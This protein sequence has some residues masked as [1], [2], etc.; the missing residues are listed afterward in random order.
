[1]S[2]HAAN[3]GN[4][5]PTAAGRDTFLIPVSLNCETQNRVHEEGSQNA[6]SEAIWEVLFRGHSFAAAPAF[7]QRSDV[8]A[9]ETSTG[10]ALSEA[11]AIQ[12]AQR[13]D[14]R[15]FERLYELHSRRVYALCLRMVNNKTDAE[16]MTQDAFLQ[17]FR[18]ID[19]FRGESGFSTWLHRIT[20]NVV[21]MRLRRKSLVDGSLEEMNERDEES[22]G[23]RR[24]F[25]SRD[26]HLAGLVDRLTLQ[27]AIEHLPAGYRAIFVLHD[28]EGYE[29][30]EIAEIYGCSI[31]NSKS[32]LHK[33]RLRIRELLQDVVR[34]NVCP[35]RTDPGK[36]AKMAIA[37]RALECPCV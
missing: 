16:D 12:M 5:L 27:R 4:L 29:H 7:V 35:K 2:T 9:A 34:E 6:V 18:K 36:A 31:G 28:V 30:H 13:G 24:E 32:Q 15:A 33:A 25:G 26:L 19:T 14:A 1:V 21:L 10:S 20:V 3:F 8:K 17:L 22:D 37:R 11:E 23:P